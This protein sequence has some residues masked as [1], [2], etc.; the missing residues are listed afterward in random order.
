MFGGDRRGFLKCMAWAGTGAFLRSRICGDAVRHSLSL[1]R[2]GWRCHKCAEALSAGRS[3]LV[4]QAL[5]IGSVTRRRPQR[6]QVVADETMIDRTSK[7]FAA[8]RIP[9]LDDERSPAGVL[10]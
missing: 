7:Q 10:R 3:P 1:R 5:E 6:H 4:E 8:E 2:I 9:H